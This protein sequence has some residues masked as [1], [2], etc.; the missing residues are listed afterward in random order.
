MKGS[1]SAVMNRWRKAESKE[2]RKS[3]KK[4]TFSYGRFGQKK[5][6]FYLCS[7]DPKERVALGIHGAVLG[8]VEIEAIF[9]RL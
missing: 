2:Q 8:D 4:K 5:I 1:P 3:S 9:D 7:P 6:S